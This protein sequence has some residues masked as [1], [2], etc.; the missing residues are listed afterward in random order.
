M[1]HSKEK[2]SVSNISLPFSYLLYW[3]TYPAAVINAFRE[4]FLGDVA[5]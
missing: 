2:I 3:F 1:K 5:C 4:T